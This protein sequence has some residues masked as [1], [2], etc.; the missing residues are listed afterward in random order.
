MYAS[1]FFYFGHTQFIDLFLENF[2]WFIGTLELKGR[3]A[4]GL[5]CFF[6]F[7]FNSLAEENNN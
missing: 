7:F 4:L 3:I 5:Y 1:H 6:L 2:F